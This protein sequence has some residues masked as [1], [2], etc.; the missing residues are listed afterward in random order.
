M[1]LYDALDT[2]R[3]FCHALGHTPE[4][5][6]DTWGKYNL[7]SV[8]FYYEGLLLSL[9]IHK[10][11]ETNIVDASLIDVAASR[12]ILNI[13]ARPEFVLDVVKQAA[14]RYPASKKQVA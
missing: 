1:K 2:M 6:T 4:I 12:S 14:D 3:I 10:S 11:S 5:D 9:Y 13:T 8:K 7:L